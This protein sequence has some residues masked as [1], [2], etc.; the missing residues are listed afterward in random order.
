MHPAAFGRSRR[1]GTSLFGQP[2]EAH[3]A[4][5]LTCAADPPALAKRTR[6]AL[7][8]MRCC[9][10]GGFRH[11][12]GEIGAEIGYHDPAE[13]CAPG[14]RSTGERNADVDADSRS[15]RGGPRSRMP[16]QRVEGLGVVD[17][18]A[19]AGEDLAHLAQASGS[20]V[21][22][23]S[24]RERGRRSGDAGVCRWAAQG[25]VFGVATSYADRRPRWHPD[26]RRQLRRSA[27]LAHQDRFDARSCR[28][29]RVRIKPEW[30]AA[31]VPTSAGRTEATWLKNR[32]RPNRT[33]MR[34]IC[35]R[36]RWSSSTCS[37]ISSSRE[38]S[39]KRSATTLPHCRR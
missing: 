33:N 7:P 12:V 37:A 15:R 16:E 11:H 28:P 4:I 20:C 1:A 18:P 25:Q 27:G 13:G 14:R 22:L 26:R 30:A 2:R 17:R 23:R 32:C 31:A 24:S 35:R 38:V 19:L 21:R 3:G 9:P 8:S 6:S 36:R 5:R 29:P 39:A 10:H 34:S